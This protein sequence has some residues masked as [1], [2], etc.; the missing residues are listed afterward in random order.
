MSGGVSPAS[1]GNNSDYGGYGSSG[2]TSPG[3][4]YGSGGGYDPYDRDYSYDYRQEETA[5]PLMV[6]LLLGGGIAMTTGIGVGGHAIWARTH[7]AERQGR[8]AEANAG[9]DAATA[10]E[11]SMTEALAA[12]RTHPPAGT[13]ADDALAWARAR[14][15]AEAGYALTEEGTRQDLH[16]SRWG[17]PSQSAGDAI[18]GARGIADGNAGGVVRAGEWHIPVRFS[19]DLDAIAKSRQVSYTETEYGYH[20]GPNPANG[21]KYEYHYGPH[22]V[23]KYR[24][25]HYLDE[26]NRFRAQHDGLVTAFRDD[27]ADLRS[28]GTKPELAL[29]EAVDGVGAARNEL[30]DATR[31]LGYATGK[32]GMVRSI[33]IGVTLAGA[34]AI[35]AGLLL[36][37]D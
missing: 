7:I 17:T 33:M 10:H 28:V 30:D 35:A 23:T 9:L 4:D 3:D 6:G 1:V 25:E 34:G 12:D 8:V 15:D 5:D 27:M 14:F 24:T 36:N 11:T 26:F 29:E 32:S 13:S 37:D 21:G 31:S 18:S 16:V 19:E 22:S 20:S 2:G